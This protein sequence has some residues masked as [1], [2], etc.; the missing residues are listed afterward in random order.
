MRGL[1][2]IE[3]GYLC[4]GLLLSLL[5]PLAMSFRGAP[6]AEVRKTCMKI[7]WVGQVLLML[8]GGVI[9]ASAQLATFAA[10]FGMASY[11]GCAFM[12]LQKLRTPAV[13]DIR[14]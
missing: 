11:M 6:N 9:L 5:L 2:M 1:N 12:L 8:A 3:T 13:S 10:V 14:M 7:V 4:G